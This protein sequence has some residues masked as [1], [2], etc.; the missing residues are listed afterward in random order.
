M[1]VKSPILTGGAKILYFWAIKIFMALKTCKLVLNVIFLRLG[2]S[3]RYTEINW[4]PSIE[5]LFE[6]KSSRNGTQHKEA[7]QPTPDE[8]GN[9][10]EIEVSKARTLTI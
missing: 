3:G 2:G 1:L 9:L 8:E 4:Q 7:S 6:V 10:K 5:C